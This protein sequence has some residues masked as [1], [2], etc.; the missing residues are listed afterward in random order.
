[1][2]SFQSIKE[3]AEGE[4]AATESEMVISASLGHLSIWNKWSIYFFL[5]GFLYF[6]NLSLSASVFKA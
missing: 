4:V 1:M 5:L 2:A 6:F 3:E